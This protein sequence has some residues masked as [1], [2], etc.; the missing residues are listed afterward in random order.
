MESTAFPPTTNAHP[1]SY[2]AGVALGRSLRS[3]PVLAPAGPSASV[4]TYPN[5]AAGDRQLAAGKKLTAE[6]MAKRKQAG[7][8]LWDEVLAHAREGRF[9][10][11]TDVF[12]F[13]SQGMFFVAPAQESFMCR[14]RFAGGM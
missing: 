2:A 10:K 11:G 4:S 1:D 7:R 8:D 6:E 9:P 3:L 5:H 12:V 14:L 13:K